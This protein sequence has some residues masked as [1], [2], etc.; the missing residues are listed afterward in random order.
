[1]GIMRTVRDNIPKASLISLYKTV[2][3]PYIKYCNTIWDTCN[4]SLIDR[5]HA[6][7]NRA[8]KTV[9]N[10]KCEGTDHAKLLK[11]LD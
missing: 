6:L 8:A 5:P 11:E 7:Q 2:V 3:E 4:S 9:A 10:V 1:M